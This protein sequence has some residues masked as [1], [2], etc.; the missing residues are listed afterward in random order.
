MTVPMTDFRRCAKMPPFFHISLI[1]PRFVNGSDILEQ[2]NTNP[3]DSVVKIYLRHK[4]DVSDPEEFVDY[5]GQQSIVLPR[6]RANTNTLPS[7]RI[8]TNPFATTTGKFASIFDL[9]LFFSFSVCVLMFRMPR[10]RLVI[11]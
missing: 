9:L 10:D 8:F 11:I 6:A 7:G 4:D 1:E 5:E 3:W 2:L